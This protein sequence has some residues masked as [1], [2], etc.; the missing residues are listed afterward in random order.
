MQSFR[1]FKVWQRAHELAIRV[2]KVA[3]EFPRAQERGITMQLQRSSLSVPSNIA[4]GSKR[5]SKVEFARFLNIAE[6]SAAE[7]SY[8]LL[9]AR[10]VGLISADRANALITEADEICKMLHVFRLKVEQ[11]S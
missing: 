9:F 1:D 8:Q 4:E 7:M 5:K 10:D 11:S 6:G 3:E 2:Y